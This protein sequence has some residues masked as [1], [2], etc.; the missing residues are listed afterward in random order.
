MQIRSM[1]FDCPP[2]L[3]ELI[4]KCLK[5]KPEERPSLTELL[6]S[7]EELRNLERTKSKSLYVVS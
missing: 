7:I 4:T 6:N 2:K 1:A 5:P 3:K